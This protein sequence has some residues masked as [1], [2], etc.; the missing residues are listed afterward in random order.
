MSKFCQSCG[1]PLNKDPAGGGTNADGS[2][3]ELYCSYC[4]QDGAFM[5]PDMDV[6]EF[7]AFCVA[8]MKKQGMPGF[9]AWLFTRGIPKLQRWKKAPG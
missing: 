5:N 8:Q 2:R 6:K 7:Q 1:M 9:I 4:Y 3:S